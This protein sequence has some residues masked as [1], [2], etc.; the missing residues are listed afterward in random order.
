MYATLGTFRLR[1]LRKCEQAISDF[2]IRHTYACYK[3]A[4]K[5]M[6]KY[7]ENAVKA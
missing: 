6:R 1:S 4:L 7:F 3:I 2:V 5:M